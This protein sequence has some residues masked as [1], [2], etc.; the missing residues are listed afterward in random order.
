MGDGFW[1]VG[2]GLRVGGAP[3]APLGE[4]GPKPRGLQGAVPRWVPS[5]WSSLFL[6]VGWGAQPEPPPQ[7]HPHQERGRRA[8]SGAQ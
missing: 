2:A 3:G 1:G 7:H 6:G 4:F 8:G 5:S